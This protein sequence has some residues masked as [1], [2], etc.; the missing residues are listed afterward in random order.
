MFKPDSM[1]EVNI[2]VLEKDTKSTVSI[3]HDLELIQFFEVKE[4]G[5]ENYEHYD[6]NEQS[7]TLLKTRSAITVLK[8]YFHHQVIGFSINL[9]EKSGIPTK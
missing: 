2:F 9:K 6:L 8:K 4:E 1:K 5:F 7:K 3:L